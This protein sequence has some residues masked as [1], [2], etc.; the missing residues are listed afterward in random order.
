MSNSNTP[1]HLR[2]AALGTELGT[3]NVKH[4]PEPSDARTRRICRSLA[5]A[6]YA[7]STS[8]PASRRVR[9]R[10]PNTA[11]WPMDVREFRLPPLRSLAYPS[12]ESLSGSAI[13]MPATTIRAS[14]VRSGWYCPSLSQGASS[15]VTISSTPTCRVKPCKAASSV[16]SVKPCPD[17]NQDGTFGIGSRRTCPSCCDNKVTSSMRCTSV[18]EGYSSPRA[19]SSEG[20]S[21]NSFH[22]DSH[23]NGRPVT[24]QLAVPR[25]SFVSTRLCT[26]P[27]VLIR[28][29]HSMDVPWSS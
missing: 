19:I 11:P 2:P 18:G 22:P 16:P 5:T 15:A 7:A 21:C 4:C 1:D 6:H 28:Q 9:L 27:S 14:S 3:V 8:Q 13:S 10:I 25:L 17:S 26:S 29:L 20:P 12:S 24:R 23:R